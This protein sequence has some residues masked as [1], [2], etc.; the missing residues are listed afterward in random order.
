MYRRV[1]GNSFKRCFFALW[2]SWDVKNVWS[3]CSLPTSTSSD[4]IK[5]ESLSRGLLLGNVGVCLGDTAHDLW[6]HA[7]FRGFTVSPNQYSRVLTQVSN[8]SATF[9]NTFISFSHPSSQFLPPPPFIL[10]LYCLNMS[11]LFV[12]L[13]HWGCLPLTGPSAPEP[14]GTVWFWNLVKNIHKPNFQSVANHQHIGSLSPTNIKSL[15]WKQSGNK[16]L[17]NRSVLGDFTFY[18]LN[19]WL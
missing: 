19:H 10:Q 6:T 16:K 9:E 14:K 2:E 4:S 5:R 13:E 17:L 18:W 7:S 11:R 12:H 3:M 8:L 15:V 1:V